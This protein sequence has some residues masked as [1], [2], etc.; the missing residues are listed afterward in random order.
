MRRKVLPAIL[1]LSVVLAGCGQK[2]SNEASSFKANEVENIRELVQDYSLRNIKDES[3]SITSQ[4]LIVE[5]SDGKE[6]VYDLSAEDF[7]VSIAP[8]I[9]QT[10]P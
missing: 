9:N 6:L 10:H 4:Q 5:K 1:F 3:A 7:F 8:F 2:D